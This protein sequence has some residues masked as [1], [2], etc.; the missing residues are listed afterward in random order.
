VRVTD[1]DAGGSRGLFVV[2]LESGHFKPDQIC[3]RRAFWFVGSEAAVCRGRDEVVAAFV[4]LFTFLLLRAEKAGK[5][6]EGFAI[7][8]L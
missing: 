6:F 3:V 2:G 5:F 8:G 4:V 1:V 7:G